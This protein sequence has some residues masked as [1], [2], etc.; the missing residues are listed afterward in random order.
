[1]AGVRGDF[2][3]LGR[4]AE[5]FMRI[6]G[7]DFKKNFM[8]NLAEE[9]GSFMKECFE[10]SESPYGEKW[11]EINW[12]LSVNGNKQKPLLDTGIMHMCITPVA[13][14]ENNFSI[15]VGRIYASTHQF[16]AVIVPKR[17]K[18]LSWEG[19]DYEQVNVG[20]RSQH[21]TRTKTGRVFRKKVRIPARPFAPLNGMPPELDVRGKEAAEDFLVAFFEDV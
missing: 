8:R 11:E 13:V 18:A 7:S 12:R 1:M 2:P 21:A 5:H 6:A 4:L 19:V 16:G 14:T 10:K 17:A 3:G 15:S 9:Y 20:K